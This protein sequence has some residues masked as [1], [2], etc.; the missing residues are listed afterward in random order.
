MVFKIFET[1]A[2]VTETMVFLYM[3]MGVFTDRYKY[4]NP[5]FALL[6][7]LFCLIGRAL[8]IVPLSF[9]S[10]LCRKRQSTKIP[11]KMQF[12][13]WFAGLR[14]AI[15][16]ALAENMPGSNRDNYASCT[17]MIC[18]TTTV[19][20]GGCTEK[21][22][23]R[24][25]MKQTEDLNTNPSMDDGVEMVSMVISD[26][27]TREELTNVYNGLKGLCLQFDH[28]YLQPAFGGPIGGVE[29]LVDDNLGDYELPKQICEGKSNVST[30]V[31]RSISD[32]DGDHSAWQ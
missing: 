13:L 3:G 32:E 12:V 15:A 23:T 2:T 28:K 4:W 29:E 21:I 18:I 7:L 9:F 8:N 20:F 26:P 14:G 30:A 6:A 16:F 5:R 1:L 10:N 22:L 19:L 27:V 24:F 17:L 31:T 11:L 25:G